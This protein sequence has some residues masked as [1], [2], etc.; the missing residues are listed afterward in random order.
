MMRTCEP[1]HLSLVLPIEDIKILD[2]SAFSRARNE[3][4]HESSR[5]MGRRD[6]CEERGLPVA[7]R[8]RLASQIKLKFVIDEPMVRRLCARAK[9]LKLVSGSRKTSTLRSIYLDT[10]ELALKDAGNYPQA[11]PRWAALDADRQDQDQAARR[12]VAG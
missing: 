9:E 7:T 10:P 2:H 6:G 8:R 4:F 3:R 12:P 11:P 1:T 5:L